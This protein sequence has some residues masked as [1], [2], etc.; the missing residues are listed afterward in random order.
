[1]V[2]ETPNP[3]CEY[4]CDRIAKYQFKNSKW[5]C[6]NSTN[7][8]PGIRKKLSIVK[9]DKSWEEIYGKEYA[10]YFR[11]KRKNDLIGKDYINRYGKNK[12]N[13][14]K[15]K[16]SNKNKGKIISED[17]KLSISLAQTGKKVSAQQKEK[18]RLVMKGRKD[19]LKTRKLKS[20]KQLNR[21]KNLNERVKYKLTIKQIIYKY[22]TF[23]KIE[24]MRYNPI[25]LDEKEIQVHCKNHNCPN[26]K[27][28][29]G[30]FTPTYQQLYERM[31]QIEHELGT[32]GSYLYCSDECK[33]ECP[34]FGKTTNQLIKEDQIRIGNIEDP[35]YNSQEYQVWRNQVFELDNHICQWCGNPATIAHHILSQKIYPNLA[36]DPENGIACCQEC[37]YKYGHRDSWCTTGYL[38][39]LVC[40]RIIR[41]KE[42]N[43][44]YESSTYK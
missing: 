37:H 28:Q 41:I 13:E 17:H 27:E 5:C 35:W 25:T 9:K 18:Q 7:K 38:S 42:N 6:S 24:E 33:Q 15:Q 26:S 8:C 31:R 3:I 16:I 12:A 36:L 20:K 11:Y 44:Y 30:W 4:G 21:Y 1:M 23:S 14:I 22:S 34:L 29:G 10:T 39:Q 40:E 32:D 19:S 2:N 43:K